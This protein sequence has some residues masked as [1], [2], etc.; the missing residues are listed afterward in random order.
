MFFNAL[1]DQRFGLLG[2]KTGGLGLNDD[3]RGRELRKD[4][5]P[6]LSKSLAP[7]ESHQQRQGQHH[8][9]PVNRKADDA[10]EHD[11]FSLERAA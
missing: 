10:S 7:M 11:G 1:R 4:V 3:P 8:A 2:G 5:E 9:R 6:G